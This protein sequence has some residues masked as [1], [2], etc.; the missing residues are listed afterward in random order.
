MNN[1]ALIDVKKLGKVYHTEGEDVHALKD[2]SLT[3]DKGEFVAIMGP[4][5][6]GKSTLLHILGLLDRP[7]AGDYFFDG[8]DTSKFTDDELAYLRNEEMGFVF[9]KYN[10]LKRTTVYENVKLPLYY[11]GIH[12]SKWDKLVRKAVKSVDLTDRISHESSQ[13]SGG[14]QQRVAIARAIVNSPQIVFADEPTGNLDS[15]AGAIVMDIIQELN[16]KGHTVILITHE[17][18]TSEY[19]N[20]LVLLMD[21]KLDADR[22]IRTGRLKKEK[23]RK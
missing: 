11:S 5:G 1:M 3:I 14:E 15:E 18:Y 20:R 13:L 19:A 9:Q 17:R 12:P 6:S 7:T 2:I 16:K 21:G 10:L 4:S 8:R 22:P 23:Y